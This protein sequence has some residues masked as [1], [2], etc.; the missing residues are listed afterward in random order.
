MGGGVGQELGRQAA[1]QGR[2][3]VPDGDRGQRQGRP[4]GRGKPRREVDEG[5]GDR[6]TDGPAA[7]QAGT[8]RGA[9]HRSTVGA[10]SMPGMVPERT[11]RQD[12]AG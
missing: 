4:V 3:Q 7:E 12:P 9:T 10:W 2:R 6:P 1:G 11:R 8:E 5:A